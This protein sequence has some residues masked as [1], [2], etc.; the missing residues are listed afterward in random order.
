MLL[1]RAVYTCTLLVNKIH[2]PVWKMAS[3]CCSPILLGYRTLY[4]VPKVLLLPGKHLVP[5][6]LCR[7]TYHTYSLRDPQLHGGSVP[8]PEERPLSPHH[9]QGHQAQQLPLQPRAPHSARFEFSGSYTLLFSC[10]RGN[11]IYALLVHGDVSG[12]FH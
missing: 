11:F 6:L 3:K 2:L 10:G 4:Q 5:L 1:Y 7:T 9:S 8:G 12:V